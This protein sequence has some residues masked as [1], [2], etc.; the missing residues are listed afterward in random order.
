M[1]GKLDVAE[2]DSATAIE[3]S[4]EP[5]LEL[6]VEARYGETAEGVSD[7]SGGMKSDGGGRDWSDEPRPSSSRGEAR[8]SLLKESR[9]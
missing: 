3:L 8:S 1:V 6:L 9:E 5:A 4:P 7:C 2:E